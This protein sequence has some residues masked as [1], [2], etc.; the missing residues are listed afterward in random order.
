M[1][2]LF[3]RYAETGAVGRHKESPCLQELVAIAK[4]EWD[5]H[6]GWY[7]MDNRAK[8]VY[9]SLEDRKEVSW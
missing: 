4:S 8:S 5:V 7:I 6:D 2:S 9:S 1:Y 3:Y